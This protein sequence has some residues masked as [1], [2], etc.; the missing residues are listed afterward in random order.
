M[1]QAIFENVD[2][3][4]CVMCGERAIKGKITCREE[5]HEEF[6]KSCED[7]FG[8]VKKVTDITTGI[9]YKVPTRNIIEEGLIWRNLSKYPEWNE[10]EVA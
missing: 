9:S 2:K 1:N 10:N 5:C 8:I 3:G 7:K 4:L 6:I